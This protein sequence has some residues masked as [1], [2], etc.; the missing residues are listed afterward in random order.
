MPPSPKLP[1]IFSFSMTSFRNFAA[2]SDAPPAP[3]W[4]LKPSFRSPDALITS[5]AVIA[6]ESPT[7]SRV[8]LVVPETMPFGSPIE[9]TTATAS[10]SVSG[11]DQPQSGYGC[12]SSVIA[13]TYF[14]CF[15][16]GIA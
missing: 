6:I 15:A 4:K 8:I 1:R 10:T 3:V 11:I 12:S 2:A 14:A 13:T 16:S 5:T 9:S 7:G